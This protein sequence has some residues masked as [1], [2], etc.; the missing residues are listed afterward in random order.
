MEWINNSFLRLFPHP[1]VSWWW[2]PLA[3]PI[4]DRKRV[5]GC[6]KEY[7]W[8]VPKT[9]QMLLRTIQPEALYKYLLIT[10]WTGCKKA[11]GIVGDPN[12][13]Q[14]DCWHPTSK[15]AWRR[16]CACTLWRKMRKREHSEGKNRSGAET[17]SAW[18]E[19]WEETSLSP[20]GY[21]H[22]LK[23]WGEKVRK[24]CWDGLLTV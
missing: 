24:S 21:P 11:T 8:Y 1:M 23:N 10:M 20:P 18:G 17:R 2:I 4:G 16:A 19:G 14:R 7:I 5:K 6:V 12:E 15:E 3:K 9:V 22:R 13:Q